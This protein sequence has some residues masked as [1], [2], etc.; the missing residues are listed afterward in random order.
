MNPD[1]LFG[2]A[3]ATL[4]TGGIRLVKPP[5]DEELAQRKA[6]RLAAIAAKRAASPTVAAAEAKRRRKAERLRNIELRK[7]AT[8]GEAS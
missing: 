1:F 8:E 4:M 3:A 7:F 2:A 6:D 5:T